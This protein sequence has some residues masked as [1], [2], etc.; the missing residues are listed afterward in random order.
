MTALLAECFV[1]GA[2]GE[3]RTS[4]CCGAVFGLSAFG[5][6]GLIFLRSSQVGSTLSVGRIST[7]LSSPNFYSS[8]NYF[9]GVQVQHHEERQ[10]ARL[11]PFVRY[12]VSCPSDPRLFFLGGCSQQPWTHLPSNVIWQHVAQTCLFQAYP[13]LYYTVYAL[14]ARDSSF[15]FS[16][17]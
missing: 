5:I 3:N 14:L 17:P 8:H 15:M 12:F 7:S 11:S 4:S 16:L 6:L 9:V 10:R 2:G 1:V 13:D